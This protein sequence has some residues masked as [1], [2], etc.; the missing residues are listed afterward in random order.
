MPPG[1]PQR[2]EW[3]G[4]VQVITLSGTR[5]DGGNQHRAFDPGRSRRVVT[6]PAVQQE[7]DCRDRFCRDRLNHRNPPS[8]PLERP[9]PPPPPAPPPA[10][11][12]SPSPRSPASPAPPP[13]WDDWPLQ[14][15]RAARPEDYRLSRSGKVVTEL[16]THIKW[17]NIGDAD[18]PLWVQLD[19]ADAA[20]SVEMREE[21][22]KSKD[23]QWMMWQRQE[24]RGIHTHTRPQRTDIGPQQVRLNTR[25]QHVMSGELA[26]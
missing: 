8:P 10:P 3:V 21:S 24:V 23:K 17:E 16:S 2:R 18:A 15:K 5:V 25:A 4:G 9:P 13:P 14:L 7:Y 26:C 20:A 19:D 6:P 1:P 12:H 11:P 22:I